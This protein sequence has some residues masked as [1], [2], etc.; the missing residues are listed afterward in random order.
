MKLKELVE[1]I[2]P[3]KGFRKIVVDDETWWWRVSKREGLSIRSPKGKHYPVTDESDKRSV[4]L[5]PPSV[6][7]NER[8]YDDDDKYD[9]D[10]EAMTHGHQPVSVTPKAIAI[11]IKNKLKPR[12]KDKKSDIGWKKYQIEQK[13]KRRHDSR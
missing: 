12:I 9:Y 13:K 10:D 7:A 4:G 6:D 2:K 1:E 8:E 11:F 5:I 3:G